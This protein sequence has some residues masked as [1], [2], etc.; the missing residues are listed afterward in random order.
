MSIVKKAPDLTKAIRELSYECPYSFPRRGFILYNMQYYS[1]QNT[2]HP[3]NYALVPSQKPCQ[4]Q[5]SYRRSN[6]T[7]NHN[8]EYQAPPPHFI[9]PPPP[10]TVSVTIIIK[11]HQRKSHQPSQSIAEGKYAQKGTEGMAL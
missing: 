5:S 3:P 8:L 1:L 2:P 9:I 6:N 10:P 7:G 11:T 4:S